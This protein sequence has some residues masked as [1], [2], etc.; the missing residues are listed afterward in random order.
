M[1]YEIQVETVPAE[2]MATVR[3]RAS[4]GGVAQVWKPA[5]DQVWAFLR[6]NGHLRPGHN[7]FLYHQAAHRNEPMDID[8]GVQV[9]HPFE[10]D[11]NVRCIATPAGEVASTVH[12]GPYYRTWRHPRLVLGEQSDNRAGVVGNLRRLDRRSGPPGD[13]HQVSAGLS[14]RCHHVISGARRSQRSS[15]NC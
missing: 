4:V 9:S 3:A 12:V 7:L 14:I 15:V 11:G 13:D 8:F 10:P 5:L 1:R 6:A 2:L